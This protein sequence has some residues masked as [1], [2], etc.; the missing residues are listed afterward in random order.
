MVF[1]IGTSIKS[2]SQLDQPARGKIFQ[3]CDVER[4]AGIFQFTRVE[5]IGREQF[6]DER[7][8]LFQLAGAEF[9][10]GWKRRGHSQWVTAEQQGSL[11]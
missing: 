8:Q 6:A 1:K 4:D 5:R 7:T 2:E 3:R 11:A 9:G 10:A